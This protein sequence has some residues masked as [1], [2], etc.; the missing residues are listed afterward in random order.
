MNT[1][2]LAREMYDA[3][4]KMARAIIQEDKTSLDDL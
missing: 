2:Q 1:F 4:G 3:K